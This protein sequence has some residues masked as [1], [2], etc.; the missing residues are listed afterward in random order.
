MLEA[1]ISG[2]RNPRLLA[3]LAKG[4]AR[5]RLAALAEALDGRF[6]DHHARLARMLLDQ[7]DELTARIGT[8]TELLDAAIAALPAEPA[9]GPAGPD[10]VRAVIGEIGLDM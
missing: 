9:T 4:R 5:V 1:L 6:T 8:V 7:I 2:Q 10:S 3:E